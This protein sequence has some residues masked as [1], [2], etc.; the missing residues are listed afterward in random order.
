MGKKGRWPKSFKVPAGT[1]PVARKKLKLGAFK[2]GSKIVQMDIAK[3]QREN[4]QGFAIFCWR[5]VP[6]AGGSYP[7]QGAQICPS[8]SL[9]PGD[10]R[11]NFCSIFLILGVCLQSGGGSPDKVLSPSEAAKKVGEKVVVE[12]EVG[13]TGGNNNFYI[14]TEKDF[15]DPKNLTIILP[16]PSKIKF[17]KSQKIEDLDKH[18]QGKK[19]RVSGMVKLFEGKPR[20]Q[21]DEPGQITILPEK[22][23]K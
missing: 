3:G 7:K 19:I 13:S 1:E 8:N 23:V 16:K 11:M 21:V 14:N 17:M 4:R 20:I 15:M 2:V 5:T 22:T 9:F 12:F 10:F 6:G 18:F